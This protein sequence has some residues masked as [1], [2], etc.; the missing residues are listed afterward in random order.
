MRRLT[1]RLVAVLAAAASSAL[2]AG[3]AKGDL[4]WPVL[5]ARYASP[6]SRF[7]DLPGGLR[8]H[9]RDQGDPK[10][11][12]TLVLVHGFAASLQ[13]WEPWVARLAPAYRVISLD[14]PGHGLTRAPA[15]YRASGDGDVA[16]ID[17]LTRRLGAPR[18]VLGGNSMGGAIAWA[19]ALAHPERL[20]GLILIDAAGWPRA[21][22]PGG[23][24]VVLFKLLGNPA[25]RAILAR[26]DPTPMAR[27]GLRQAYVDPALVTPALVA[28]YVDLARAPGHREILLTQNAGPRKPVTPATFAAIHTP[29]LVL[30]GA[31][32][33]V[34]PADDSRGLAGA[35]PGARLIV[36]PGVGHVPMEQIPERSAADVRAFVDALPRG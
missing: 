9:Y 11:A 3:C 15:G 28:R 18:F 27:R 31:V 20:N 7:A 33:S 6:A 13:A 8:I 32:D 2:L 23:G 30:V 10:A 25:G 17:D 22:R 1:T 24:S 26:I 34:I 29:T 16:V 19:Y 21:A 35:I 36:Y 14:L 12:R 5:E 4:T